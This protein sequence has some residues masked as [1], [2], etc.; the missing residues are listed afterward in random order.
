MSPPTLYAVPLEVRDLRACDFYH[1]IELPDVGLVR[2]EWD[3]RRNIDRYLGHADFRG[4]RVLDV[5]SASGFLTFQIERQGGDVISYDLSEDFLWDF[6]P[7]AGTD[8]R[9]SAREFRGKIKRLNHGYWYCHHQLGSKA[10]KVYG[11]VYDIPEAIGPV[12]VSVFGS[13]LLHLRDPFLALQNALQLTRETAIVTEMLP[14]RNFYQMFLGWLGRPRMTF[15]PEHQT[16]RHGGTWWELSPAVIRRFLGVLGF[17]KTTVRYHRQL[18]QGETRLLFT[19][20]G[21]RT[22]PAPILAAARAFA[23]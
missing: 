14:R 21:Q 18:F 8:L 16:H 23:A 13:I 7:F 6:V 22:R 5:G 3:L 11:T 17:E 20:V 1:T 9:D 12:D 2:G 15:L 10:R 19:V 4:K